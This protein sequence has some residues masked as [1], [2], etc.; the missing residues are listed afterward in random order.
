M[1]D[2]KQKGRWDGD[3]TDRRGRSPE[4][5]PL[6]ALEG[7]AVILVELNQGLGVAEAIDH[8]VGI[9]QALEGDLADM[10][11]GGGA[12]GDG[13]EG[14]DFQHQYRFFGFVQPKYFATA[15]GDREAHPLNL[16]A[17]SPGQLVPQSFRAPHT[18]HGPTLGKKKIFHTTYVASIRGIELSGQ[19]RGDGGS[20]GDQSQNQS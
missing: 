14:F 20:K 10:L 11:L 2:R 3:E 1:A 17:A 16:G 6:L 13:S 8:A 19:E 7:K 5:H 9:H 18:T 4:L 15:F 12:L